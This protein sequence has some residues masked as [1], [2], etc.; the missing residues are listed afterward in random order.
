MRKIPIKKHEER[1]LVAH[2]NTVLAQAKLWRSQPEYVGVF[3][4]LLDR[5]NAPPKA[6]LKAVAP[7]NPQNTGDV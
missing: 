6:K 2:M 4:S 7:V 1:I 3:R 5:L